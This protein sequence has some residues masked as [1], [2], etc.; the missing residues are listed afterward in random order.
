MI[1]NINKIKEDVKPTP[2]EA[3]HEFIDKRQ[4]TVFLTKV[5]TFD[6]AVSMNNNTYDQTINNIPNLLFSNITNQSYEIKRHQSYEINKQLLNIRINSKVS[7]CCK[8]RIK[9]NIINQKI[10]NIT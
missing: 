5:I 8:N 7:S 9:K 10:E 1:L 6:E 3:Y 4:N 2:M